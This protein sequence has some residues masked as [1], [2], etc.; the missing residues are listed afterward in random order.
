M[1]EAAESQLIVV[2]GG[3][4]GYVAAFLA[5]DHGMQVT[6]I[7][8]TPKPGGTCLHV[9]CIPSKALLHA[10]RIIAEAKEAEEF[11]LTFGAPKIDVDKLRGQKLKI[12]D[13]L[14]S[15]LLE[16]CKKRKVEFINATATF[17]DSHTLKLSTGDRRRFKNCIIAVGSSPTRIPTLNINSP[18]VM[19]S[20][21]ALKLE[22]IP[23]SLLVVGGGYIGL[24]LG[25]VY[26]SL[27]TKVTVVELTGGLLPGCDR[28]LVR[29]LQDRLKKLF[30][31]IYLDTKVNKLAETP[32]GIQASLEGAEVTDKEPVFDRVLVSVGRRPN[33]KG[34]GLENTKVQLDE[35][36][37]IKIDKQCKTAEPHIFAIGDVAGEPMLA[38]K[39]SYEGRVAAEVL[40]GEPA[41]FDARAIPAVVFTDPEIA[42]CGLSESDAKKQ[43]KEIEVARFPWA[44]SGRAA[45]L[46]RQEG[47]TKLV[48]EPETHRVLGIGIVG[49]G[50]GEMIAEGVVAVEMGATAK[51]L[52]LSIHAHPTLSETV[53]EAAESVYGSTTHLYRAKK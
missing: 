13:K 7:D 5:A 45:T 2:G 24:E 15:N 18:R 38:H 22:Q 20:T 1:A 30:A 32:K 40:L 28:D 46:G 34:L 21:G 12:V 43:G 37:F 8:A 52:A 39:A 29:P 41:M 16:L 17:E 26:A 49:V 19:D 4:G 51:D 25:L 14:S 53:M 44:A 50:A 10:A 23:G 6:L 47:L 42:W 36:G 48:L 3:P 9:G 33:S 31:N 11:G 27:G 35:K